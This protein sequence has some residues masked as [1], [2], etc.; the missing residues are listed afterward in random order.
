MIPIPPVGA[1]VGQQRAQIARRP[2]ESKP[3]NKPRRR[4]PPPLPP[5]TLRFQGEPT[6]P[7]SSA[8]EEAAAALP[9]PPVPP[10]H[11]N[12]PTAVGLTRLCR[13]WHHRPIFPVLWR[14]FRLPPRTTRQ[15]TIRDPGSV[16]LVC[17]SCWAR[18]SSWR[19]P[20]FSA[21]AR[22]GP[23]LL[24]VPDAAAAVQPAVGAVTGAPP[25]LGALRCGF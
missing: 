11:A 12:T 23:A 15:T 9:L 25:N 17:P 21:P 16:M 10:Q 13:R 18:A 1:S 24:V 14:A 2:P 3:Q 6:T 5:P 20:G 19:P 4:H 22:G 8:A 7:P